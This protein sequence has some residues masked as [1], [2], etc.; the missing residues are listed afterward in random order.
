MA[1]W[2]ILPIAVIS[3]ALCSFLWFREVRRIMREQKSTVESAGRQLE[4]CQENARRAQAS[5]ESVSILA[6]SEDIYRQAVENYNRTV[7]KPL[8][9]LPAYLMGYLTIP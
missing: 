5:P 6:R 7:L 2:I 9:H 3:T 8:Y 4:V 1:S